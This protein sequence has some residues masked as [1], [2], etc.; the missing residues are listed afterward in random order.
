VRQFC[1]RKFESEY[2]ILLKL[3]IYFNLNNKNLG[4]KLTF[5][6]SRN[7]LLIL[8]LNKISNFLKSWNFW[9]TVDSF[10]LVVINLR[11]VILSESVFAWVKWLEWIF[12]CSMNRMNIS[13]RVSQNELCKKYCILKFILFL[14]W[15]KS[16]MKLK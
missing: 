5:L 16:M 15:Q 9:N 2:N 10:V 1:Q 14:M 6:Y 13:S 7:F 8:N 12:D 4:K 3:L 11:C